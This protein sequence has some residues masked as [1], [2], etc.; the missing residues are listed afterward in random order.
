MYEV[1]FTINHVCVESAVEVAATEG[2]PEE[3]KKETAVEE[4]AV[5]MVEGKGE[6]EGSS[7]GGVT[8]HVEADVESLELLLCS[9]VGEVAE[10]KIKGRM[11]ANLL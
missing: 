7:T 5:V 8:V 6:G 4:K 3:E 1:Y 11:N 9:H 2:K 10:I